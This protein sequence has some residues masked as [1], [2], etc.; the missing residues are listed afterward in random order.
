MKSKLARG[1]VVAALGF[2]A[3]SALSVRAADDAVVPGQ[4][5]ASVEQLKDQAFKALRAGNFQVG[6]NLL[7][8]AASS[9]NDPQLAMMSHWTNQFESQL[10]TFADERRKA[11]E[12]ATADVKLLIDKGHEDY[13]LDHATLAQLLSD[14]KKAFH[15][16]P[17]VSKLIADS[18]Q[19]AADDEKSEQ[20]LK[21]MR[22]YIDLGSLEPS[23]KEWK[24]KLKTVTRRVRLLALYTPDQ[25]KQIQEKESKEHD[26]VEALVNPKLAPSTQPTTQPIL[27]TAPDG[28]KLMVNTVNVQTP[29]TEPVDDVAGVDTNNFRID[30][31]E[32]LHGIKMGMLQTSMHEAFLNYYRDVTYKGL[33]LGGMEG[34]EAVVT[35]RGLDQAF[36]NLADGAKRATFQQFLDDWKTAAN[37]ST[38]ANEQDL[39]DKML[40]DDKDGLL[41]VNARTVQLPEEV[42]VSEFA[43][44]A[45]SGLD[46]FTSMIWPSELEEFNKTTQ[47]E[48]SGVG[49]QIKLDMVD[50]SLKV[51]TPLEDSPAYKSGIKAGDSITF[52]NG[53]SAKGITLTQA[54][55]TITGPSGTM[56]RLTVRSPDSTV[57]DH[58]IR[59][60]TI[61][62]AS[63]K[64]YQHKP[65]GGWDYFVDPVNKIAYLR[66]TNFT[67]TTGEE[68]DKTIDEISPNTNGIILDLRG[69]PGGLLT[70][71][72]EVA[73]KFIREGVIVSTHPDRDTPNPPQILT[74][75]A[76]DNE[77]DK[78][79]VVLVNQYSASASEIVSGALKDDHRAIIV[80]ERTFGKGSVQ[81]LFS[82]SNR[83]SCLKLTTSHYY[84]PSGRCI[85]REENSTE[86]GVDPDVTV[87]VTPEQMLAAQEARDNLDILRDASSPPADD[88]ATK[89]APT[90]KP[91]TK[92]LLAI[93]PQLSAALL[94]LRLENLGAH[95]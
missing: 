24:E 77:Y 47:G 64:G 81:M 6:N 94:V 58:L 4:Q 36:P 18:V 80:G 45:L 1:W 73:D 16:E 89:S 93:D 76:D 39:I 50:G 72:T 52:I 14:D 32:T 82:L 8:Q 7:S 86:W 78:P 53:R 38:P 59:R 22:I 63:V 13:A 9:S 79:L 2:A 30:W 65:G 83:T 26:E 56:V 95:L 29:S 41:A 67:K 42:L 20:W 88:D 27:V 3:L 75:R 90:T 48:F 23:S 57:K 51:A 17:W 87:E 10:Q 84:L 62:V 92:D 40:S 91:V 55:K 31:H 74:A 37:A 15:D 54:V 70:A 66:I 34:I 71:A 19:H 43:D 25:L 69:N 35:T 33:M 46:P 49:I 60:E 85:H 21:A 12:K 44:G 68:L 61:K 5:L 28:T 11:C